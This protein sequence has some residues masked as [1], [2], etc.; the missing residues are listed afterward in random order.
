MWMCDPRMLEAVSKCRPLRQ[1]V[2]VLFTDHGGFGVWSGT[3]WVQEYADMGASLSRCICSSRPLSILC[4][5]GYSMSAFM[6]E[7][8][9]SKMIARLSHKVRFTFIQV[10][11]FQTRRPSHHSTQPSP[12]D[13]GTQHASVRS[14]T[15]RGEMGR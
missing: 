6:L 2:K 11:S 14:G 4:V 15:A 13:T 3:W 8:H 5:H 9:L 7:K 10:C 12:L 1:V